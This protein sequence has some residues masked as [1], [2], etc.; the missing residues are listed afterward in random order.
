MGLPVATGAALACP[1]R[2]VVA[3]DGDGSALYTA[4]ALWT[5]AREELDVTNVVLVNRS[6]AILNMEMMRMGLGTAGPIARGML[7]LTRPEIDFTSLGRSL[8]V[9]S[10]RAE[11][12][13]QLVDLL[14]RSFAARGPTLIEA[15][16][17]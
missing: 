14:R 7:D 17:A 10:Q 5:Q 12:A 15:I 4:Q 1:G 13:D 2:R 8:G 9:P 3:L 16:L 11:T 6:Y